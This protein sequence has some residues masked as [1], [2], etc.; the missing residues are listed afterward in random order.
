MKQ[1]TWKTVNGDIANA[2]DS[3]DI[4]IPETEEE[5]DDFMNVLKEHYLPEKKLPEE[6]IVYTGEVLYIG[7]ED[8]ISGRS[9]IK[10]VVKDTEGLVW[11]LLPQQIRYI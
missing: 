1:V 7:Q 5:Q 10:F 9:F 2:G 8:D 3:L 4:N 6:N 11:S